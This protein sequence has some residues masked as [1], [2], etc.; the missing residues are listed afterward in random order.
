MRDS[1]KKVGK[2]PVIPK[3]ANA[4]VPGLQDVYKLYYNARSA[5]ERVFGRIKASKHLAF[6]FDKLTL[7]FF[8]S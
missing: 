6:R 7:R 3:R 2:T 5:K 1:I 8:S 4:V